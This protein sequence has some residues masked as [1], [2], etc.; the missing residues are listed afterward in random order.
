MD[1]KNKAVFITGGSSGIGLATAKKLTSK[2]ANVVIYSRDV[3]AVKSEFDENKSLLIEGDVCDRKQVQRATAETLKKFGSLDIL[4]NN[5]GVAQRKLFSEIREKDWDFILDVNVKGV[6]VVTQE[7]LKVMGRGENKTIINIASGAG[8]YGIAGLSIYS[9]TKAAVI[10]FTQSLSQELASRK[11][12]VITV[13][14]G[15]TATEMFASLFPKRE[16]HHTPE[17]V[18]EVIYK[19]IAGEIKPDDRLIV[20]VFH[21]TR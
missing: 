3:H 1:V 18:A 16:P 7:A 5:A 4:V 20:D 6:F 9:A 21:H 8:I 15:S 12:R 10:N 13:A 17:Q 19:T 11:I 2:G 14:P